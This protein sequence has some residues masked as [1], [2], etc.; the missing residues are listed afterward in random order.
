MPEGQ[1]DLDLNTLKTEEEVEIGSHTYKP[2][3]QT[4]MVALQRMPKIGFNHDD[5]RVHQLNL[6]HRGSAF[7]HK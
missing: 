7:G 4:K 1:Y 3:F 6:K 5:P 2:V